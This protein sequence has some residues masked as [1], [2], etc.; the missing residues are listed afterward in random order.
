MWN[1]ISNCN[2]TTCMFQHSLKGSY[3]PI[4]FRASLQL[5]VNFLGLRWVVF[6][7]PCFAD[8]KRQVLACIILGFF[9]RMR[10]EHWDLETKIDLDSPKWFAFQK[11]VNI[12]NNFRTIS[13][14]M[15]RECGCLF[16]WKA[17]LIRLKV[18][19]SL[20]HN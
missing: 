5:P 13:N 10:F 15:F 20:R 16:E 14:R 3:N 19:S 17:P 6:R 18:W 12:F 9:P 7:N 1:G 11:S 8:K 2:L 4:V